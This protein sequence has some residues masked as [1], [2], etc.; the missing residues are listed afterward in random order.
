MR[1]DRLS[2]SGHAT[3]R[4]FERRIRTEDVR[5]VL[6]TGE[7]IADYPGDTPYPSCLILG[8]ITGHPL[9]VVAA[10]DSGSRTCYVITV[11]APDP[12]QWSADFRT[13][14]TTR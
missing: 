9:H 5:Q 4:M 7:V 11:Y 3:V 12:G 14:R 2:F 13:R 1:F 6:A 10:L 8:W